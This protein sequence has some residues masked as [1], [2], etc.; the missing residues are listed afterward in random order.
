MDHLLFVQN[1]SV[2]K[3][4][5][6]LLKSLSSVCY[7]Y[8]RVTADVFDFRTQVAKVFLENCDELI[9]CISVLVLTVYCSASIFDWCNQG[10]EC[11]Y[12]TLS[13]TCFY[14]NEEVSIH[15][16]TSMKY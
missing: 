13:A 1:T 12:L 3:L 2:K 7:M 5:A 14:E 8:R 4:Y 11:F 16:M 9:L 6:P 15:S 10:N